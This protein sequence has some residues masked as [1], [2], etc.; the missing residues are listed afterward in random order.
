MSDDRLVERRERV[1]RQVD[2]AYRFQRGKRIVTE[3][4]EL[5]LGQVEHFQLFLGVEGRRWD[6]IDAVV[7]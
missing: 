4:S 3:E 2:A 7:V 1:A 5:V 6:R